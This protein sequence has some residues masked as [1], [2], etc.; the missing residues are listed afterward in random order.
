VINGY[1]DPEWSAVRE[2]FNANLEEGLDAGASLA[3]SREGRPV[4]DLWGGRDPLTGRSWDRETVTVGFSI[5]KGVTAIALLQLV[6]RGQVDLDAPVARYW[7]EFAQAGKEKIRVRD[8]LVHR[9]GIPAIEVDPI[10]RVLDWDPAVEALAVQAPQYDVSRFFVY[11]VLSFG[12]LVGEIVRRVSGLGFGDYVQTNISGP[13]GLDLWVGTPE[14]VE[15]RVLPGLT[16]DAA[17][18]V[19]PASTEPACV[20]GWSAGAQL[21]AMFRQVDGVQGTEPFNE[22][23][24]RAAE[25]PAGNG[26]TNAR[27]MARMYAACL[28]EVDGV[29][30]LSADTIAAAT[31][32]QSAGVRQGDCAAADPWAAGVA[33]P[34]GLG[35]EISNPLN[36]MLGPGS[37]GHAGM[38]GRLAFAH[39]ASGL[40]FGYVSQ[41]MAYPAPGLLD[42]RWERVLEAVHGVLD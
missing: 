9:V 10:D 18:P 40:S 35:F 32:D 26:V 20:A 21:M 6:E 37:F 28:G 38:G 16:V 7:P 3:I 30:L 13:L 5:T 27:A 22:R 36:P 11:H 19:R 15:P 17:D 42:P 8:V 29:R 31:R 41:Q 23:R 1:V 12:Y 25:V 4:V 2:A 33:Q 24:F 39:P 14:W 34:W